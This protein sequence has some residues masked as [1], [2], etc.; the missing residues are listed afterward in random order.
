MAIY[1]VHIVLTCLGIGLFTLGGEWPV[2]QAIGAGLIGSGL[3]Y[4]VH[5]LVQ[6]PRQCFLFIWGIAHLRAWVYVSGAALVRI[7]L[8]NK[9][10]LMWDDKRSQYQPVGGALKRFEGARLPFPHVEAENAESCDVRFW[11]RGWWLPTSYRW[12]VTTKDRESSPW[13]EFYDELIRPGLLPSATSPYTAMRF[14]RR[15]I[16]LPACQPEYEGEPVTRFFEIHDAILE[17]A[18]ADALRKSLASESTKGV[19]A[20][21]LVDPSQIRKG[22]IEGHD[23]QK[24]RIRIGDHTHFILE[25]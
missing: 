19:P 8:D 24:G 21:I 18:E 4:F 22:F 20:I 2:L 1:L 23:A 9:L 7:S 11:V 15:S 10:L 3:T 16:E 14:L 25:A 17:Q 5:E 6:H 13:R 12:F